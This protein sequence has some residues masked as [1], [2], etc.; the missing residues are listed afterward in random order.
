MTIRDIFRYSFVQL[1]IVSRLIG[2]GHERSSLQRT[3]RGGG[4][5]GPNRPVWV[6]ATA[7]CWN[8]ALYRS[9]DSPSQRR[10]DGRPWFQAKQQPWPDGVEGSHQSAIG[11]DKDQQRC[12]NNEFVDAVMRVFLILSSG[13][14]VSR[15]W[16]AGKTPPA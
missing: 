7:Q 10:G 15:S 3:M 9:G 13:Q 1:R 8:A 6:S 4:G 16:P 5:S 11:A 2:A 14:H 12:R